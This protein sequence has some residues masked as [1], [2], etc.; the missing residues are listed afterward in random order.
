VPFDKA[1]GAG[2]LLVKTNSVQI[3]Q[4]SSSSGA[5]AA[6][7]GLSAHLFKWVTTWHPTPFNGIGLALLSIENL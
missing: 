2:G 4:R 5:T 1:I 3:P 7:V 6:R